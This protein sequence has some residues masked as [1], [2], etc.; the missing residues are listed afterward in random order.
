MKCNNP[1]L[2]LVNLNAYIKNLVKFLSISSQDIEWKRNYDGWND[3]ITDGLTDSW[4]E[5]DR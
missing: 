3:G 2:D 1:K 4:M 5:F